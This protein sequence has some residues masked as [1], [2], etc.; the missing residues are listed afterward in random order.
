[1]RNRKTSI[2]LIALT[3]AL[4]SVALPPAAGAQVILL[5]QISMDEAR[6]IA[7]ENGMAAIRDIKLF[8]GKWQIWGKDQTARNMKIEINARTGMIEWLDRD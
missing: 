2:A 5:Q 1:M 3:L 6:D 7:A 8:D 4:G